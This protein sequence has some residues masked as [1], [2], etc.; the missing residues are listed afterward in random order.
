MKPKELRSPSSEL[1]GSPDGGGNIDLRDILRALQA[2]RDGDFSARLPG[3]W[4]GLGGK[5]A[6]LGGAQNILA[7]MDTNHAN[8]SLSNQQALIDLGQLDYGDAAVKLNGY[9]TAVQA[10][11]KAYAQV[12]KLSLFDVI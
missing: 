7:T 5:I 1:E 10:T 2:V 6:G 11:Q 8:V 9:T 4:Q 12:S 3:D